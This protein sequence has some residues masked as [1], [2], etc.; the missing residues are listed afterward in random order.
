[1]ERTEVVQTIMLHLKIRP[2]VKDTDRSVWIMF[3]TL[4]W[5]ESLRPPPPPPSIL[6]SYLPCLLSIVIVSSLHLP[7]LARPAPSHFSG[8]VKEAALSGDG[9]SPTHEQVYFSSVCRAPMQAT[10]SF[11]NYVSISMLSSSAAAFFQCSHIIHLP[12][13]IISSSSSYL[14]W[15]QSSEGNHRVHTAA[16]VFQFAD[17]CP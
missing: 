2:Y 15:L 6:H 8:R 16:F 10:A 11:F 1:M 17:R 9:S 12:F 14:H 3:T 7:P 4:I 5:R 13:S